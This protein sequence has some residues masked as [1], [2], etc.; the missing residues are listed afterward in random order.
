MNIFFIITGLGVGGAEQQVISLADEMTILGHTVTLCYITGEA[1]LFPASQQ[2]KVMSLNAQKNPWSITKALFSLMATIRCLR[3][4]IIHSHMIHANLLVRIIKP[5]IN[6]RTVLICSAHNKNEGGRLRMLAYRLTDRLADISTNVS[7]EAVDTFLAK[8]ATKSGRMRVMYNGIDTN[9]FS[10]N[11]EQRKILRNQWHLTEN[12]KV[13]L[14]IGRLTPAKDYPNLLR[15][16]SLLPNLNNKVLFIVGSGEKNYVNLLHNLV[17]Q[18]GITERVRFLGIRQDIASL[19]S[20]S[21]LFVLTSEWE[22]MPLVVAEAMSCEQLVVATDSGGVKEM[23]ADTG[24]L[25]PTKQPDLL[26]R[27]IEKA[28]DLSLSVRAQLTKKAR[29][30]VLMHYNIHQITKQWLALYQYVIHRKNG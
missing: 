19:L 3:P 16:F 29:Q 21:D 23:L 5:F 14:A 11:N 20:A 7:Q 24:F 22:G 1:K 13:L 17:N 30:R 8:K 27:S 9:K 4:D 10:F 18:L 2:T 6:K 26:A 25:V 15:A 28:L 12:T